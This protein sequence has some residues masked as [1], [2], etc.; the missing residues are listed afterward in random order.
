LTDVKVQLFDGFPGERAIAQES[1]VARMRKLEK[2]ELRRG[3]PRIR[4]PRRRRMATQPPSKESGLSGRGESVAKNGYP[5]RD[6][7]SGEW[8]TL[9]QGI[10]D[11]L[12]SSI[13]PAATIHRMRL[14]LPFVMAWQGFP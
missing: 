10:F 3:R 5:S 7:S 13:M 14:A 8:L 6:R 9:K 11:G 1:S 12:G 2:S 4:G